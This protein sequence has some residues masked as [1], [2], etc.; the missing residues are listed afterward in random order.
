MSQ[1]LFILA[2]SAAITFGLQ[3][4]GFAVAFALQTETFYDVFGKVI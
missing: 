2:I 1:E 4:A 3:T